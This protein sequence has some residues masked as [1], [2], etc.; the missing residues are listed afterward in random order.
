[1]LTGGGLSWRSCDCLEDGCAHVGRAQPSWQRGRRD[2]AES[3]QEHFLSWGLRCF[4]Q[5]W[6]ANFLLHFR[7]ISRVVLQ[8]LG[9]YK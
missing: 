5:S 8:F 4:Q 2:A 1:M 7:R 6:G 9:F 3:L